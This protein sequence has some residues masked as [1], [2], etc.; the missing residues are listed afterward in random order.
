MNSKYVNI[1]LILYLFK[2]SQLDNVV[3]FLFSEHPRYCC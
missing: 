3:A 2:M 1:S